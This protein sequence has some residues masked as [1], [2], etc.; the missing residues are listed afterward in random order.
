MGLPR[1]R[2][3]LRFGMPEAAAVLL[4]AP[5]LVFAFLWWD[6]AEGPAWAETPGQVVSGRVVS[7]HYNAQPYEDKVTLTYV[8]SVSGMKFTGQWEGIWPH[9]TGPNELPE[10]Q[11]SLLERPGYPLRI[12]YDPADPRTSRLHIAPAGIG[13]LYATLALVGGVLTAYYTLRIYPAWKRR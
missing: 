10:D 7:T 9:G 4:L 1:R 2:R 13:L 3:D 6:T 11:L 5:T 8:Y 12:F